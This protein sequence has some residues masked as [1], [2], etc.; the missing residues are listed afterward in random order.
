MPPKPKFTREEMVNAAV[1]LISERGE[2]SL[3]ARELGKFIGSSSCPIF[4]LFKDMDELK[5]EVRL[6][7]VAVFNDYM[8]EADNYT[9][10]YKKRGMQWVKF[11]SEQPRLFRLLFMRETLSGA[12]FDD[13][14]SLIP[15]GK[16]NDIDI[17]I[18]DYDA[19]REQAE[20]LF[21]HMWIYT[22]GMCTLVANKVCVFSEEEIAK[23]L[24]EAFRGAVY[25]LK[26]DGAFPENANPTS[27][28]PTSPSSEKGKDIIS[29][30]P[31]LSDKKAD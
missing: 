22:Y 1:E 13:A 7:A 23:A 9:P 31:K 11:A 24:G 6:K 10:A 5:A 18:R 21:K 17:I 27:V 25:V 15:F 14:Q 30:H 12:S 4:T 19:T 26:T 8:A 28:I 2:E 16:Q 20:R 29:H 3:T